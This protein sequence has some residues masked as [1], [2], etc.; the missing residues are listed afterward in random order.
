LEGSDDGSTEDSGPSPVERIAHLFAAAAIAKF[1]E[2]AGTKDFT[3]FHEPGT[4]LG[5]G[6]KE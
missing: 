5:V 2:A 4:P 6:F 1:M 3:V